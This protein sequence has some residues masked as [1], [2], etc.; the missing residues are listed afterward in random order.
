MKIWRILFGAVF[1]LGIAA[2]CL[3]GQSG[4][5]ARAAQ[6]TNCMPTTGTISGLTFSTD[7]TQALQSLNSS[8]LGATAPATD[9]SAA[10]VAGQIWLNSSTTPEQYEIYDGSSWEV[11]GYLNTSTH[12]W[13]PNSNSFG[14]RNRIINGGDD[15][16]Q[17]NSFASQTVTT[18]GAYTDDRFYAFT[19]GASATGQNVAG[20]VGISRRQ[21]QFTGAA[22]VAGITR[23]Q[24]IET[25]NSIDLAGSTATFSAYLSDSLLTSVTWSVSSA[26]SADSFGTLTSPTVTTISSGAFTVSSTLARYSA[27]VSVPTAAVTGLQVCLSVGSQTSGTWVIANEQFEAGSAATAFERRPIGVELALC[28][29]YYQQVIGASSGTLSVIGYAG[30]A[31]VFVSNMFTIPTMRTVPTFAIIGTW[32]YYNT[33]TLLSGVT[34]S[35]LILQVQATA[36]GQAYAQNAAGAGFSLSAEL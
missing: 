4:E 17:R 9:C 12:V 32:N 11:I 14:F 2:L 24:R 33:S 22:S 27:T 10:P 31:T 13:T 25:D 16:D 15:V 26:T 36:A 1:A 3:V 20:T 19:T 34:V 7:V 29:R 6:F 28:Q 8:N 23:C 35:T 30:A 18:S 21:Y 5:S